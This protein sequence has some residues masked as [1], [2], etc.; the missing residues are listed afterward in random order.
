[1]V[2]LVISSLAAVA[3]GFLIRGADRRRSRYGLL[4]IPGL[5]LAVAMVLWVGLQL[6]GT[7]SDP[8]LHWLAWALPPLAGAAGGVLTACLVGP[9]R[10]AADNAELER[11]LRL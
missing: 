4:L 1:M 11:V 6:A 10:E 9:R 5:S 7:G 2:S 3:A 8:D